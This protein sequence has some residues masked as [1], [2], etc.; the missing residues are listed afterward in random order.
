LYDE[1]VGGAEARLAGAAGAAAARAGV[2]AARR[3]LAAGLH[4]RVDPARGP[5][6]W[7]CRIEA[8]EPGPGEGLP[9]SGRY[10]YDPAAIRPRRGEIPPTDNGD[11]LVDH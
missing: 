8:D 9:W 2:G 10:V 5:A 7:E 4:H 6:G 3:H 11:L 1:R